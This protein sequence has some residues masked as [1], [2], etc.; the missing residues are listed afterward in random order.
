MRLC[1]HS[2]MDYGSRASDRMTCVWPSGS[3]CAMGIPP[4]TTSHTE[5]PFSTRAAPSISMPKRVKS[6]WYYT[7]S[8]WGAGQRSTAEYQTIGRLLIRV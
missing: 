1:L 4:R 8:P 6:K 5:H 3:L 2:A 7:V